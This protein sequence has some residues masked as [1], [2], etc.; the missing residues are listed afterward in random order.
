M[1]TLDSDI[2]KNAQDY[3]MI[4]DNI[5]SIYMSDGSMNVLL[6]FE[7]VLNELDIFAFRNWEFGELVAGPEQGPY[8]T[9]CTF[10]WPAQLMPDPRAAM[11]LLPFDCEVYWKK[12][13]M[14]VPVKMKNASDFKP[15]TKIARLVEK[16]VWL[17]EIIMPRSLMADIKTGSVEIEDETVDLQ[18]LDDAYAQDLDQQQAM[19][20]DTQDEM[21][22]NDEQG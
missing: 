22:F 10:L 18:D 14:K 2:F 21:E 3:W 1:K 19:D 13:K 7:R 12:T 20:Q 9:S 11:R 16:P 15:G 8:K 17:V 5:K 6:D 4:A